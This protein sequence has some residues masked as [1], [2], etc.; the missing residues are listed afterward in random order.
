MLVAERGNL[1]LREKK[2]KEGRGLWVYIRVSWWAH[3]LK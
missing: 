1:K 2:M 3:D